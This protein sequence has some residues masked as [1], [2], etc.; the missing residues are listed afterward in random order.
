MKRFILP[1]L[2]IGIMVATV[3]G[4]GYVVVKYAVDVSAQPRPMSW[5]EMDNLQQAEDIN[6]KEIPRLLIC[7]ERN[8]EDLR[9]KA[10][11]TLGKIGKPAVEPLREK[12]KSR[13]AKV[14]FCAA[15]AL[16]HMGPAAAGAS[17]ELLACL[18][19]KDADV[20][21]K[22]VF[23]LGFLVAADDGVF[24]GLI[25]ALDD[26]DDGVVEAALESIKKQE[27]PPK[28]ALEPLT[29]LAN[30]PKHEVRTE[31]IKLL[32]KVGEPALPALKVLLAKPSAADRMALYEA[33]LPLGAKATPLLP[34][35]QTYML[36]S[37]WWDDEEKLFVI[38]KNCGSVG[39]KSLAGVLK[40]LHDPKSPHLDA[41]NDRATTILKALGQ[42][43][44]AAKDATPVLIVILKDRETIRPQVLETFGDI[45]PAAKEA[46]P[47]VQELAA[48]ATVGP[49]ARAALKRMGVMEEP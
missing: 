28:A 4:I 7:F 18:D 12:L 9:V 44:P 20:R 47:A 17:K 8:D 6:D 1:L 15:Q 25:K 36:E 43:G 14:R 31:A 2:L 13:N 35:L 11:E 34:D 24:T 27:A 40:S 23:T 10:A 32:G 42:M 21:R 37:R 46:I 45:G 29:K 26:K 49:M 19:D 30:D 22:A 5:D 3:G 38:F 39:A 33:V 41:A 48:D 16:A